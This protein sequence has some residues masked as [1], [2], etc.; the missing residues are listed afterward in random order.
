MRVAPG[1]AENYLRLNGARLHLHLISASL[2]P[3]NHD[4]WHDGGSIGR[5]EVD[6]HKRACHAMK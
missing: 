6:W 4:I 1:R 5:R 2:Q 3:A